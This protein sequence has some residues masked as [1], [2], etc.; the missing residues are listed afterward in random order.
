M[1]DRV[2]RVRVPASTSNMGPGFDALGCALD[3][4]LDVRVEPAQ[5]DFQVRAS[6]VD[7]HKVPS[8]Q[9]N[10]ILRAL[11]RVASRRGRTIE[12]LT[13]VADNEIPLAS[14][15]GSSAAAILAGISC[16]EIVTG[17]R[18]TP[19][20]IMDYAWEF[21]PHPDNLAAALFGGLTIP[22][23]TGGFGAGFLKLEVA[24]GL[25]PVVVTP[26]LEVPT[27]RARE[28]LPDSYSRGDVVFNIQ[29]TAQ[30]VGA[31]VTGQ[32]AFLAEAMK[33]RLHQ[34]YRA[35][36]IPGLEQVLALKANGLYGIALSGAGPSVLALADTA[37]AEDIGG[38]VADVFR[39]HGLSS[40]VRISNIDTD[41]R[42][43]LETGSGVS[44]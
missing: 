40:R 2:R 17:D 9:N 26:E 22:V 12:P 43:F 37:R 19:D 3:L 11:L 4:Y 15:L 21:E 34:P 41:G 20:E 44:V 23:T 30:L 29:R 10:L 35:G 13:L 6:G 24:P 32:W 36:L 7:G 14:G 42:R 33:D 1:M 27:R 18:L 31:L 38:R 39:T 16:Y 28:V 25:V 8:D 5:S